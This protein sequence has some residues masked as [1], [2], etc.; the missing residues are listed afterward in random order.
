MCSI[1]Q[2]AHCRGAVDSFCDSFVTWGYELNW[3]WE[4]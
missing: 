2:L 1:Y 3:A 4:A